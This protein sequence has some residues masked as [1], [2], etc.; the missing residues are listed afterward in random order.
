MRH[1]S[2][3]RD[4]NKIPGGRFRSQHKEPGYS[5]EELREKLTVI[6]DSLE[7][8]DKLTVNLD[9]TCGLAHSFLDEAFS[10]L[11]LTK[12]EFVSKEEPEL[13]GYIARWNQEYH[14]RN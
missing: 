6:I 12:I 7:D 1:F 5:G 10:P 13:V 11:D 8:G 4:F 14:E 2:I 3:A 9:G